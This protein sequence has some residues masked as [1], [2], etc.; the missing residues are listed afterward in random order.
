MTHAYAEIHT[1][2]GSDSEILSRFG[3]KWSVL[4]VN[5]TEEGPIRF[6][7]LKR[8]IDR[9]RPISTRVLSRTLRQLERDGLIQ[10]TVFPVIPP[11]VEYEVTPLGRHFLA[12]ARTICEWTREQHGA[13]AAARNAF[14]QMQ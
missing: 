11:R 1:S 5:M 14:D 3:D 10:R 6:T 9:L 7:S 2:S 13:F 12:F 8:A 4:V